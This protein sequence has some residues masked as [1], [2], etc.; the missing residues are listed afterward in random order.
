IVRLDEN[1]TA[2]DSGYFALG[3]LSPSPDQRLLAY[4]TDYTG[5]ERYELRFRDV[6]GASEL[7]DV[8]P[9]TYYGLGWAQ[10]QATIVY[11]RPDDA[12]RPWQVWRHRLGT[13]AADDELVFEKP[14]EGFSLRIGATARGPSLGIHQGA[15]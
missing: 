10:D 13:A 4:S 3:A 15:E 7:R 12:M 5:G 8:V 11:T 6:D 2:S 9:D 14:D 1:A